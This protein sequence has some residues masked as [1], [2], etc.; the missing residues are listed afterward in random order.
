M[1]DRAGGLKNTQL[2]HL[3]RDN[4]SE[5]FSA[6][7]IFQF[8]SQPNPRGTKNFSTIILATSARPVF[9]SPPPCFQQ[10]YF[11]FPS[12]SPFTHAVYSVWKFNQTVLLTPFS[13]LFFFVSNSVSYQ[14]TTAL[15]STLR[16]PRVVA[17][18][19]RSLGA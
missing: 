6:S 1:I 11:L 5:F 3:T 14:C 18:S 16:F 9:L 7:Y 13:Y 19:R 17:S 4:V 12:I 8:F 2:D 10:L 15:L